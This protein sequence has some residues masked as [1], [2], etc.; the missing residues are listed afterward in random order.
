MF[1]GFGFATFKDERDAQEAVN[2]LK[3][4]SLLGNRILVE[5]AKGK[6]KKKGI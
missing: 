2:D 1:V 4:A 6:E 3:N 5:F